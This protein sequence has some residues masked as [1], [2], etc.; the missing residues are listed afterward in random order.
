MMKCLKENN[1]SAVIKT[2]DIE[3]KLKIYISV[4][5][6]TKAD[7]KIMEKKITEERNGLLHD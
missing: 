6:K 7:E 3:S 2:S 1:C 4:S 5:A